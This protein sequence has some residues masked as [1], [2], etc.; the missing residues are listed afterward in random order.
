MVSRPQVVCAADYDRDMN[1]G[2]LDDVLRR[3]QRG[4]A[5]AAATR[6][7]EQRERDEA[8]RQRAI[9]GA[10]AFARVTAAAAALWRRAQ[11]ASCAKSGYYSPSSAR[12]IPD[13]GYNVTK[14]KVAWCGRQLEVAP[15]ARNSGEVFV[16]SRS[17][18]I[19]IWGPTV[20]FQ[21]R[22]L[23]PEDMNARLADDLINAM[24]V[25]LWR[26]GAR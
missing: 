12:S 1:D 16:V 13:V 21:R 15:N 11:D 4:E 6:A 10:D 22:N 18:H 20:E 8:G 5:S 9:A 14:V 7:A 24:G 26:Q 25:W 17:G 3:M 23:V 19:I 2:G